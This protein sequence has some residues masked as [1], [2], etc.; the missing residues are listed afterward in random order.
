MSDLD[1]GSRGACAR[2]RLTRRTLLGA[3]AAL[4]AQEMLSP[5]AVR[6]APPKDT[7]AIGD[8]DDPTIVLPWTN[9]A[10]DLIKVH[11]PNPVRAGRGLALLHVALFTA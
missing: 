2:N 8:W 5:A 4:G 11:Q 3:T 6:A 10:L 9:L 1:S 7:V